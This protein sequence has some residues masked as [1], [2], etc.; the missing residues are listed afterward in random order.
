MGIAL[1]IGLI[2]FTISLIRLLVMAIRL[3]KIVDVIIPYIRL[4]LFVFIFFMVFA[5]FIAYVI[6]N[7][8]NEGNITSGYEQY[9]TCLAGGTF[10][11]V[12]ECQ[13]SSDVSNF[14]LVMLKGFAL[15]CLGLLLFGTFLSW[16]ILKHWIALFKAFGLLFIRPSDFLIR[17]KMLGSMM[18]SEA[19]VRSS[20]SLDTHAMSVA[21]ET[22][23]EEEDE[24]EEEEDDDESEDEEQRKEASSEDE[25]SAS[26][27]S[28]EL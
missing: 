11:P 21:T 24:E 10:T 5:F 18:I 3:R 15:S 16:A 2:F 9:F 28:E 8:A 7:A 1:L 12:T 23:H 20:T 19:A 25:K 13:L 4:L 22:R 17:M 6:N 26:V 27:R 14:S